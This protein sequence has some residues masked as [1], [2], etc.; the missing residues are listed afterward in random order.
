MCTEDWNRAPLPC[1]WSN[2]STHYFLEFIYFVTDGTF[3]ADSG[4]STVTDG[5]CKYHTSKD[6]FSR[7]KV[8][9]KW[10]QAKVMMNWYSLTRRWELV[11]HVFSPQLDILS[12]IE[13]TTSQSWLRTKKLWD[14]VKTVVGTKHDVTVEVPL[15]STRRHC[16]LTLQRQKQRQGRKAHLRV[17]ASAPHLV[18]HLQPQVDAWN[19][20]ISTTL[21]DTKP[22]LFNCCSHEDPS[23]LRTSTAVIETEG[24][25]KYECIEVHTLPVMEFHHPP[26][27]PWILAATPGSQNRRGC[28]VLSGFPLGF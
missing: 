26:N 15:R 11:Q 13:Y 23:P 14:A 3:K 10:L 27:F 19:T 1:N 7:C 16:N 12:Q 22:E 18:S 21:T 20:L 5:V 6:V 17:C 28:S 24:I 4:Q 8:C 2:S 9:T 25:V